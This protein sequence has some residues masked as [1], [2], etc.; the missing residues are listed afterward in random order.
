[1]LIHNYDVTRTDNTPD[2]FGDVIPPRTVS[3]DD[4]VPG[5]RAHHVFCYRATRDLDR[6]I[7]ILL[8]LAIRPPLLFLSPPKLLVLYVF[9]HRVVHGVFNSP[10]RAERVQRR[11]EQARRDA[12]VAHALASAL[13]PKDIMWFLATALGETGPR[14][15]PQSLVEYWL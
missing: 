8:L 11:V 10:Y 6:F 7:G 13:G 2:D 5:T 15:A 12:R 4:T 1:Q 14:W 9:G 3:P